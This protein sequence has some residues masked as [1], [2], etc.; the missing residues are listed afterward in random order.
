MLNTPTIKVAGISSKP[1]YI[2]KKDGLL[3]LILNQLMLKDTRTMD[4]I[5]SFYLLVY[6]LLQTIHL[7]IHEPLLQSLSCF[8]STLYTQLLTLLCSILIGLLHWISV[9]ALAIPHSPKEHHH[10]HVGVAATQ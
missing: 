8:I 10:Y 2:E 9:K 7:Y 5:S 4:F 1:E 3:V 6:F